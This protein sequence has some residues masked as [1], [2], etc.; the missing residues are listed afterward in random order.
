[1]KFLTKI[2]HPNINASGSV[3]MG[4]LKWSADCNIEYLLVCVL[5]LLHKP[6]VD[7][8]YAEDPAK[9]YKESISKYNDMAKA[10]TAKY[11][12]DKCL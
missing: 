8:G 3:C 2:F 7:N 6:F 9:L 5:N 4:T 1:M 11:A 12:S 10:W